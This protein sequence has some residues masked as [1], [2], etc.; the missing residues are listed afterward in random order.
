MSGIQ[1]GPA[2]AAATG[3]APDLIIRSQTG[4]IRLADLRGKVVLVDFW[5]TWCPPCRA[6]IPSIAGLYHKNHDRGFEVMGVSLDDRDSTITAFARE[7]SVPYPVGRP[8]SMDSVTEFGAES[9]PTMVLVDRQGR[10]R[11]KQAGFSDETEK[12]LSK[13]IATLLKE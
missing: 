6:S 9:I 12:E 10:I 2:S 1:P 13:Q 11:W 4:D 7:H 5:A 3:T 8:A